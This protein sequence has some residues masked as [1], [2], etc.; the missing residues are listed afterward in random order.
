MNADYRAR[1]RPGP[2]RRL[3]RRVGGAAQRESDAEV[4]AGAARGVVL[5]SPGRVDR[6]RRRTSS[7]PPSPCSARSRRACTARVEYRVDH[8]HDGVVSHRGVRRREAAPAHRRRGAVLRRGRRAD[9]GTG[10][11]QSMELTT[12]LSHVLALSQH[13]CCNHVYMRRALARAP[14]ANW[15]RWPSSAACWATGHQPARRAGAR[16]R[17][18]RRDGRRHERRR[19]AARRGR[20][21]AAA[22][23]GHRRGLAGAAARALPA[24]RGASPAVSSRRG[25]PVVVPRV[26]REPLF[27]QPLGAPPAGRRARG[28]VHLRCR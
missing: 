25:R 7:R 21:R 24:R 15:P 13:L 23:R 3:A 22:R 5:G 26:S 6:A 12:F 14:S 8:S 18:S 10:L 16:R 20:R 9:R 28:V 19:V 17:A 11:S 4:D 27:A 2:G 1:S